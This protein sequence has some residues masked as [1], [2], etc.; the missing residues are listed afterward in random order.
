MKK[1]LVVLGI[2]VGA[3]VVTSAVRADKSLLPAN[4][5]NECVAC[6]HDCARSV[7]DCMRD[8]RER[9]NLCYRT[10]MT[11]LREAWS[12]CDVPPV[13][14]TK[15]ECLREAGAAFSTCK[16][17][18]TTKAIAYCTDLEELCLKDCVRGPADNSTVVAPCASL[19]RVP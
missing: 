3:V 12:A 11:G 17:E 19:C 13:G 10:C 2:V 6:V 16:M 8:L 15:R 18:C 7:G 14:Q 9:R 4:G 5:G 1:T